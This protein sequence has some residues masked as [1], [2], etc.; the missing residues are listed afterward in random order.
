M[1]QR[2]QILYA[3]VSRCLPSILEPLIAIR[4]QYM[5]LQMVEIK[6]TN[7]PSR[8]QRQIVHKIPGF[9]HKV[10]IR[11]FSGLFHKLSRLY[12]QPILHNQAKKFTVLESWPLKSL[13]KIPYLVNFP[14]WH[15]F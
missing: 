1:H 9:F 7:S 4:N 11:C 14:I 10:E 2:P 3:P 5:L 12:E 8:K 15:H 13:K 6:D